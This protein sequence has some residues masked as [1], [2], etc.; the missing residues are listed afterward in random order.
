M[1]PYTSPIFRLRLS[2]LGEDLSTWGDPNLNNAFYRIEE[3]VA[4]VYT[5][6][7]TGD[8]TLDASNYVA[9]EYRRHALI[10]TGSPAA[11][12]TI[13]VPP[14]SFPYRFVNRTGRQA[15]IKTAS[16]ASAIVRVGMTTTVL[17]DGTDCIALD[18]T[19]DK[20]KTA[21]GPVDFGGQKATNI[22][23]GAAPGEAVQFGQLTPFTTT[24]MRW[25][26]QTSG[27]VVDAVT[28][29]DSGTYSAKEFAQGVQA[30]TGGSAKAWATSTTIVASGF[31]GAYGY[32]LDAQSAATSATTAFSSFDKRYLGAKSADP[33][34]DNQGAALVTGAQY[35]N[36]SLNAMRVYT[37]SAFVAAYV[38]SSGVVTGPSTATNNAISLFNS[39]GS[40]KDS[41]VLFG[42]GPGNAVRLDGASKYPAADGSQITGIT[43][44]PAGAVSPFAMTTAPT[45]W[46]KC[47]G[48]AVSRSTYAALFA[49]I[50]TTF[51]PGD[52]S[53]TFGLPDLRGEFIRALDDG[54]GVDSGR[55]LGASQADVLGSHTHSYLASTGTL[56]GTP[57]VAGGSQVP[58]VSVNQN[59][60]TTGGTGGTETRPRNVALLYCIKF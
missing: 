6:A 20:I 2:A 59:S 32:A 23:S 56:G 44:V 49:A 36:T 8:K 33:T 58:I 29:T 1:P 3:A 38:P 35:F 51:G 60:A 11:D 48:A 41:G 30:G 10:L 46:M 21:A 15:T 26:T 45:G 24:A 55:A 16:G 7:I 4:S 42:T 13:T 57:Y 14:L 27:T 52:G 9:N 50:G 17:C 22:A 34:T 39:D 12:F 18:P 54:R 25:A 53:T 40:I 47:N 37:G 43:T 5:L 28:G 19:L 31:K